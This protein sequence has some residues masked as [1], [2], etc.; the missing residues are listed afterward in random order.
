MNHSN[1]DW[2][3]LVN[4]HKAL[5]PGALAPGSHD[6]SKFGAA[7]SSLAFLRG[8]SMR[9]PTGLSERID[10]NSLLQ[11]ANGGAPRQAS[12]VSSIAEYAAIQQRLFLEEQARRDLISQ[13]LM[14]SQQSTQ[15]PSM[16]ELLAKLGVYQAP[17]SLL[18]HSK[19]GFEEKTSSTPPLKKRRIHKNLAPSSDA[20]PAVKAQ[21]TAAV[22]APIV[23]LSHKERKSTFPLPVKQGNQGIPIRVSS[24]AKFG[25]TWKH[26]HSKS[27]ISDPVLKRKFVSEMFGRKITNCDGERMYKKVHGLKGKSSNN[28]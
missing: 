6:S 21:T 1:L 15:G 27:T 20:T 9:M 17:S 13:A 24:L 14:Q 11:A 3:L 19:K 7:S 22:V 28:K 10:L 2:A 16:G 25:A 8:D 12:A 23:P 26:L 4:E 5:R 18:S